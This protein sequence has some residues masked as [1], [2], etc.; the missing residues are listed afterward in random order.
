MSQQFSN[1]R[2][3]SVFDT[4]FVAP[5]RAALADPTLTT[6]TP[7]YEAVGKY[8]AETEAAL[9][10]L[11]EADAHQPGS[12]S[13]L[14]S[15]LKDAVN[16]SVDELWAECA[17]TIRPPEGEPSKLYKRITSIEKVYTAARVTALAGQA[18]NRAAAA[19]HF[20]PPGL[21]AP[22]SAGRP[23]RRP[24]FGA[25]RGVVLPGQLRA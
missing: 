9:E 11:H 4:K 12:G 8:W 13:T 22:A 10:S 20:S 23:G 24:A 2:A 5:T 25:D 14:A 7:V 21:P 19:A 15:D 17:P 16:A 18:A 3:N 1:A 6:G